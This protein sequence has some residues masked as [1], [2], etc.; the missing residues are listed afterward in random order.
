[1][2]DKDLL[3]RNEDQEDRSDIIS[4]IRD[5]EAELEFMF[6]R[7]PDE[8]KYIKHIEGTI[9]LLYRKLDKFNESYDG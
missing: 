2:T 3:S 6:L 1:M 8:I 7:E 9:E 4:H 5:L